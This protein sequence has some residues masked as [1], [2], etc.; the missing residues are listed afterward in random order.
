MFKTWPGESFT[1]RGLR[2]KVTGARLLADGRVLVPVSQSHDKKT[3]RHSVTLT[4]PARA[5]D[6]RVSVVVLEFSGKA[7]GDPMP[8]EQADGSVALPVHLAKIRGDGVRL[9]RDGAVEGWKSTDAKLAWQ[10]KLTAPGTFNVHVLTTAHGRRKAQFG[11]HEV[12][13]GVGKVSV[14]G[15]AGVCNLDPDS[16]E[17]NWQFVV[18]PL[19]PLAIRK[20]KKV[21]LILKASAIDGNA[22]LGLTVAGVKLV[23]R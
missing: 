8:Q 10:F 7:D 4:L 9:G 15:P 6:K 11:D 12:T 1:L 5:P 14:S 20:T 2:N 23:R 19:G 22:G 13:A 3:D 21:E 18:N 17:E 16:K